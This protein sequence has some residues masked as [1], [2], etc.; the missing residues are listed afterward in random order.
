MFLIQLGPRL[1]TDFSHPLLRPRGV[2]NP[3]SY[4][5]IARVA[6][7][8]SKYTDL[9]K[10][11]GFLGHSTG[12]FKNF[13]YISLLL[14]DII[15]IFVTIRT[16]TTLSYHLPSCMDSL[17]VFLWFLLSSENCED[18]NDI[19]VSQHPVFS[20]FFNGKIQESCKFLRYWLILS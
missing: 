3:R 14:F 1:F 5:S 4:I 8:S 17:R 16:K 13:V 9:K 2:P 19:I 10:A 18:N 6:I 12:K 15:K 7:L 20:C 11:C